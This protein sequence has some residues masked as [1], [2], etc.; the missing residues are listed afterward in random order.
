[1]WLHA[2]R[3]PKIVYQK[4]WKVCLRLLSSSALPG[5][6]PATLDTGLTPSSLHQINHRDKS[7]TVLGNSRVG[8]LAYQHTQRH[9]RSH[10]FE[11]Q[12]VWNDFDLNFSLHGRKIRPFWARC[13][14]NVS[15]IGASELT[16]YP[17]RSVVVK[18]LVLWTP[19]TLLCV[20]S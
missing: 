9:Y 6:K 12:H 15:V 5:V 13:L 2:F 7:I 16:T 3:F 1:M 11:L 14:I 4:N 10:S 18:F 8:P 19:C 20:N 17:R